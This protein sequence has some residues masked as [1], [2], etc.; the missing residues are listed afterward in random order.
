MKIELNLAMMSFEGSF[1]ADP[2]NEGETSEQRQRRLDTCEEIVRV[3]TVTLQ[4]ET[5]QVMFS[6]IGSH[7]AAAYQATQAIDALSG[8]PHMRDLLMFLF[9]KGFEEGMKYQVQRA[10]AVSKP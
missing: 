3:C 9:A 10:R 5:R 7:L 6:D 4:D 8:T 1:Y 2:L